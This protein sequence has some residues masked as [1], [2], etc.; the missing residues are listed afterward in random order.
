MLS[1][2]IRFACM[3][4]MGFIGI[5][6]MHLTFFLYIKIAFHCEVICSFVFLR[7]SSDL[8]HELL[9]L[10]PCSFKTI[11]CLKQEGKKPSV[12]LEERLSLPGRQEAPKKKKKREKTKSPVYYYSRMSLISKFASSCKR[13]I[14]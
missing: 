13:N 14:Y 9:Y 12:E 8:V 11:P 4:N 2:E 6:K 10:R 5:Q 1:I 3:H 7:I